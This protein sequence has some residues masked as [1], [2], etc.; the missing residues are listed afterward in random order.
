MNRRSAAPAA[1]A[2]FVRRPAPGGR[3]RRR[4][5]AV[6]RL[7][8]V[9]R[10][11]RPACSRSSSSRSPRSWRW[12]LLGQFV[13][14]GPVRDRAVLSIVV[15]VVGVV[16]AHRHLQRRAAD[17][18][19]SDAR[20]RASAFTTDRWGDWIVFSIVFGL[21]VGVGLVA[22]HHPGPVRA[23]VL[24]NG[25]VLLPRPR[26]EPRRCARPRAVRPRAAGTRCR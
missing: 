13:I 5:G 16:A 24:R 9:L 10:Q 19:G 3:P 25:A 21:M 8:Q 17:H 14:K 22:V 4:L 1:S 20:H 18:R 12:S 7:Q 26:H 6:V 2:P 15:V 11:L 23:R